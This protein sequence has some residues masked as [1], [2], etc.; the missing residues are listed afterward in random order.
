M[1]ESEGDGIQMAGYFNVLEQPHDDWVKLRGR[2]V[3]P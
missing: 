3:H 2:I 1:S